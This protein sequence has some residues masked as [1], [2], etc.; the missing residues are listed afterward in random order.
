[1]LRKLWRKIKLISVYKLKLDKT[2]VETVKLGNDGC[3]FSVSL[4]Y[5]KSENPV[6]YSFGVGEDNSFDIELLNKVGGTV[7]AFDPTPKSIRW[8]ENN[9]N[10]DRWIFHSYGLSDMD[11][12][13]D[14]HEPKNEDF[15]SGSA[16]SRKDLKENTIKVPMKRMSTIMNELGHKKVDV[17]KMDIEGSEF[18]VIPDILNS[19]CKFDQL[20]VETHNRFFTNGNEKVQKM[21]DLL[22]NSGYILVSRSDNY[23]E[24]TFIKE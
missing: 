10:D 9:V 17:L 20:C 4:N 2:D 12:L 21:I 16:I 24:L 23:E 11:I 18:Q 7:Y 8:V 15:V 5:I 22:H 14:F 1:M 6:I 19:G 13:Q 3:S